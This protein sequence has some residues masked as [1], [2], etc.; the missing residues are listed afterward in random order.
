MGHETHVENTNLSDQN[1]NS[2]TSENS[3]P[4]AY[5]IY[6]NYLAELVTWG[7]QVR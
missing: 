5:F 7:Q 1:V 2:S 6:L 4:R 3:E